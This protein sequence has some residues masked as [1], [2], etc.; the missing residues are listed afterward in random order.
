MKGTGKKW[1]EKNKAKT[2]LITQL[3]SLFT[4]EL[5]WWKTLK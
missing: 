2:V 4:G 1:H 5:L 3:T